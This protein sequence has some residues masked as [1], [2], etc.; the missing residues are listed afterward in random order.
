RN[1]VTKWGMSEKL[2]TLYYSEDDGDPF[3]GR[4]ASGGHVSDETKEVIDVEIKD[5]IDRNYQ[6]CRQIL[7]ENMDILHAMSEALMKYETI[8]AKQID[9]L[10]ERRPVRE[11]QDWGERGSGT[12]GEP[13]SSG[14]HV[15]TTDDEV[16]DDEPTRGEPAR[17]EGGSEDGDRPDADD[18]NRTPSGDPLGGPRGG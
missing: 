18:G 1:M 2:G 12:G 10:M 16:E 11:P 3:M 17:G 8:D 14:A 15:D 13:P 4:Q 6:R 5:V 9:D 7:V